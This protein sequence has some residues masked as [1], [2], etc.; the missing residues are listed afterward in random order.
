MMANF[1]SFVEDAWNQG[2]ME[3]FKAVS[4]E[5]YIRNLNGITVAENQNAVE[6][7]I[8]LFL[9]G[10]PD[11][12]VTVDQIIQKDNTLFAHWTFIGT[13]TGIFGESPPTGKKVNVSGHS[14]IQFNENGK[15]IQEDVYYNE[16]ELLQQLGYTLVPPITE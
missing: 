15:M 14:T 12:Q 16:L 8:K 10:F 5:N 1:E 11:G 9:T 4:V 13:N 3:K 6:S 2:N 7:N